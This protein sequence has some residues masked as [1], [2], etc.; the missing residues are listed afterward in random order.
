MQKYSGNNTN[1]KSP[2]IRIT[3][4]VFV[5]LLIFVV[6]MSGCSRK[7]PVTDLTKTESHND[8]LSQRSI[9]QDAGYTRVRGLSQI[10]KTG[11]SSVK[12]VGQGV[13]SEMPTLARICTSTNKDWVSISGLCHLLLFYGLGP[14]DLPMFPSGT[15]AL[16]ALTDEPTSIQTFGK[17]P[18]VRTRNG[19]RYFVIDDPL[20]RAEIGETHRDQVLATFAALDLPLNTPIHLKDGTFSISDLL[21]ES[22]ANFNF[23]QTEPA[24]TVI[25]YAKYLPPKKEW[26]NRFGERASFSQL[27]NHL[28]AVDMSRQSCAGTHIFEAVARIYQ[29]DRTMPIL[30]EKTQKQVYHYLQ[31]KTDQIVRRQEPG[32]AWNWNWCDAIDRKVPTT[33][34][35]YILVTGHILEALNALDSSL[36]PSESTFARAAGW[37]SHSLV[38]QEIHAAEAGSWICPFTHAARSLQ[39]RAGRA[40]AQLEQPAPINFVTS[41]TGGK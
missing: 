9:A 21:A 15:M 33:F 32:G 5:C 18:F 11:P 41:S 24:W 40:E 31:T 30:D 34:P 37:L 16:K 6:G 38:S 23:D 2:N 28:L 4:E 12:N 14:T 10:D 39:R 20:G 1:R 19:L 27:A 29:A 26:V 13:I 35:D 25:A 3:T 7:S 17:S 36:R 8:Q 22:V